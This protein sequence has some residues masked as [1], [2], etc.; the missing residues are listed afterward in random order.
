MACLIDS[1]DA[2]ITSEE[3]ATML[4]GS[5]AEVHFALDRKLF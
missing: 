5:R 1:L 3:H 4:T 2:L